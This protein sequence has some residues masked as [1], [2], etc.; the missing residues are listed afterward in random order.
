[1]ANS[2][3]KLLVTQN[4]SSA[5]LMI[6]IFFILLITNVKSDSFSFNLTSFEPGV[7]IIQTSTD[8]K[9][10]GGILQL[11]K[12]DQLGN[13][14]PHSVGRA[15]FT[16]AVQ[17]SDKKSGKTADFTTEFTFVVNQK[18]KG[19]GL[20]GDGFTFF[21]AS[22]YFSFSDNSTGGFLGL[23]NEEGAFNT[24]VNYVVAVEFDSFANEWDPHFPVSQ[25]PHIGIDVNSLRSVATAPWPSE[26][27]LPGAIAKARINYCSY[28]KQL[29][30][31]VTY[32]NSPVNSDV[33]LSHQVDLAEALPSDF[34]VVGFSAA[35]GEYVETHD[36]LSWSFASSL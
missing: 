36:I 32:P 6:F 14:T 22:T 15:G 19:P 27:Q 11:T 25:S 4:P 8:A 10:T 28:T 24:S 29:S 7:K 3:S 12:K 34:V 18:A 16:G 9:K 20:H 23:F 5:F 33:T 13:P 2:K 17:I 1:M 21:L 35:T 30:V 31:F 26:I